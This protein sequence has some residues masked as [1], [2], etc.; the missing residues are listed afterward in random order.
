MAK[1]SNTSVRRAPSCSQCQQPMIEET[2]H[3]SE[4]FKME[5]VREMETRGLNAHQVQKKYGIGS[6]ATAP[7]WARANVK[8]EARLTG[9]ARS[10]QDTCCNSGDSFELGTGQ[11]LLSMRLFCIWC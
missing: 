3:Y 10:M 7:V 4:A 2:I 1:F 5:V 8:H 11:P 9:S 6:S